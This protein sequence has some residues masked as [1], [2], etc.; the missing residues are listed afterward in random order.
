MNITEYTTH[1]GGY[2]SSTEAKKVSLYDQLLYGT[3]TGRIVRLY[4]GVYALNNGDIVTPAPQGPAFLALIDTV[5]QAEIKDYSLET[6]VA[7]K[8]HAIIVLS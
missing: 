7:E 5:P 2:I 6:V 1:N 4:R 8:F 3:R